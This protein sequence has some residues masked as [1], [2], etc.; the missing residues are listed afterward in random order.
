MNRRL[1]HAMTE[2]ATGLS[3][4]LSAPSPTDGPAPIKPAPVDSA[5]GTPF[6]A[7]AGAGTAYDMGHSPF[8]APETTVLRTPMDTANCGEYAFS[9]YNAQLIVSMLGTGGG[10]G[11]EYDVSRLPFHVWAGLRGRDGTSLPVL[12]LRDHGVL[13][14]QVGNGGPPQG[15]EA[16]PSR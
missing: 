4:A 1:L 6:T 5:M 9:L 16:T 10:V 14:V 8:E 12:V 13:S 3:T 2:L 7:D 11:G 15:R